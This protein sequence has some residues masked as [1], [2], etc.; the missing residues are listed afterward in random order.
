MATATNRGF[1]NAVPPTGTSP[2]EVI[3]VISVSVDAAMGVAV[4]GGQVA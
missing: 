4:V 1:W 2:P 3:Q